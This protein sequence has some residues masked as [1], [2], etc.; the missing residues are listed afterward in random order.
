MRDR[1][2]KNAKIGLLF[3]V[4]LVVIALVVLPAII[5]SSSHSNNEN[6]INGIKQNK[7]DNQKNQINLHNAKIEK[8]GNQKIPSLKKSGFSTASQ[9]ERGNKKKLYILQFADN[10]RDEWKQE[11][12]NKFSLNFNKYIPNN[13]FLLK[14]KQNDLEAIAAYDFVNQIAEYKAE[15]KLSPEIS[16]N[17]V[18]GNNNNNALSSFNTESSSSFSSSLKTQYRVIIAD[19]SEIDEVSSQL[20]NA[21]INVRTTSSDI[22]LID[23]DSNDLNAIANLPEVEWI[24]PQPRY[25]IFNDNASEIINATTIWNTYNLNGSGQIIAVADSGIDTGVDSNTTTGDIHLDFDNRIGT[26]YNL[27]DSSANDTNG[28]GTHV[29]GSIVGNGN[30]SNGQFKGMAFG[31]T[32]IFQAIG[33]DA[34]STTVYPPTDLHDLYTQAYNTSARLHSNSWGENNQVY[35]AD[36]RNTDDFIWNYSNMV[37]L[38]AAG[39]DGAGGTDGTGGTLNTVGRPAIAKNIITIGASENLRASKG[40][41]ADN[42]NQVASFSSRGPAGDKRIKPDVVSPGT[43]IVSTKSSLAGTSACT[44]SFESNGNYSYCSGTSMATPIAAGSAT[45]VRQ[46][47]CRTEV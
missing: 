26:I 39:N 44:T 22:V 1:I 27:Y 29:A 13:A 33:D 10:I 20:E 31:A 3:F 47:L 14:I 18:T 16:A 43:S 11:L 25:K 36:P 2:N 24:E 7:I 4:I 21:G 41:S 45:L 38:F 34:G 9:E 6:S 15:Y 46:I 35:G 17:T 42:I 12:E 32:L 8:V 37:I 28:H 40:T 19:G 30:R 5:F 23:A